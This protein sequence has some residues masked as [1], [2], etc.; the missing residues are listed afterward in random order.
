MPQLRK[1]F[2]S[3]EFDLDLS[4][5]FAAANV[6][7]TLNLRTRQGLLALSVAVASGPLT[8]SERV[9]EVQYL[10]DAYGLSNSCAWEPV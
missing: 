5:L 7:L 8:G 2:L 10:T 9:A 3:G 6:P 4:K 1:A